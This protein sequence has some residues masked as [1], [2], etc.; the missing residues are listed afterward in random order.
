MN[1]PEGRIVAIVNDGGRRRALIDVDAENGVIA[2]AEDIAAI[3][4][5]EIDM[6]RPGNSG[7]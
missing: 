5:P 1:H 3:N 2:T 7:C 4:I 6:F